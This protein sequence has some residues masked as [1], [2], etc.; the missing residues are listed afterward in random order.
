MVR[1]EVQTDRGLYLACH[2]SGATALPIQY[3]DSMIALTV[4]RLVW[5][6]VTLDNQD[7]D[8]TNPVVPIPF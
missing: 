3:A 8:K 7:S 1:A 2:I 5:P 6:A 4:T